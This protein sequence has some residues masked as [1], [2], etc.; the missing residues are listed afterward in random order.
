[1]YGEES[2]WIV[3]AAATATLLAEKNKIIYINGRLTIENDRRTNTWSCAKVHA[4]WF[5]SKDRIVVR[6]APLD[7]QPQGTYVGDET[8][9]VRSVNDDW[10]CYRGPRAPSL[11]VEKQG[12]RVVYRKF[13]VSPRV[14]QHRNNV[15]EIIRL[16]NVHCT[17]R[18]RVIKP[19]RRV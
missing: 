18:T 11:L 15:P 2:L 4:I 7:V 13:P 3:G 5:P 1:M 14:Q 10:R 19:S 17:P 12:C 8:L 9:L 16:A 6:E